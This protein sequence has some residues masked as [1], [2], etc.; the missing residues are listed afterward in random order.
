MAIIFYGV[1]LSDCDAFS[2]KTR[3][4]IA[5]AFKEAHSR[6]PPTE[7]VLDER[8][9]DQGPR[10]IVVHQNWVDKPRVLPA[11]DD[12]AGPALEWL[13]SHAKKLSKG[14]L[15]PVWFEEEDCGQLAIRAGK[16]W[17]CE[18]GTLEIPARLLGRSMPGLDA[19]FA[20]LAEDVGCPALAKPSWILAAT[21]RDQ[22]HRREDE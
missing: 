18:D 7:R 13:A 19:L 2:G 8:V 3:A 6:L 14:R 5:R 4:Q 17:W 16:G 1:S 22:G 15:M 9:E 21:L 11:D 10:G 12:I 20:E